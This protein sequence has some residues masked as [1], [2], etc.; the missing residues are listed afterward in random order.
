MRRSRVPVLEKRSSGSNTK[1]NSSLRGTTSRGPGKTRNNFSVSMVSTRSGTESKT[2]EDE[3]EKEVEPT[4]E[5]DLET[6]DQSVDELEKKTTESTPMPNAEEPNPKPMEFSPIDDVEDAIGNTEETV[7]EDSQVKKTSFTERLAMMVGIK[8][9]ENVTEEPKAERA[10]TFGTVST[11][12]TEANPREEQ[13]KAEATAEER[14]TADHEEAT[15]ELGDLMAKLNQIDK[16]LKHSEEDREV[17]RKELR[18]NKHEYLDSYFNL[19]KATDE[20]L[21]EMTD[22]VEA[23]NKERE[24]N[25]KKDLQQLKNRYDDVNSQIGSLEKRLDTMSKNQAESSGAIQTKLDAI[26]RNSTSQERPAADRTQGT[27]VDF[28]EPQ[29]GKRQSTPLPLTRNTVS[30]APTADKTITKS[31]NSNTTSGPGDSTASSNAGPDAMTWASTWE[32]MNRTLEAYATRNT[33]S[34]DRRDGKSRKTFKKPKEFKDDSDGCIDTWVE[35]M[36][37]HLEQDNLNDERQACTAI[38]SNLEGTALKCVVAKKEEERDTADKIFEILLNRFGS[39][40]KGHQAMMRFEKRRQRDDESIDRFLDDLES[41]RRRSDPEESTNRR[42]FSIASKFIDGVKSDDLRTMLATYYTLSKDSAP[43]PE[44]MRQKSREYMLMKPKKYSY[45]ENRNTQGGSQPQRSSWYKPRDDMDK[46]RSCANCGS[47]DHHVAD[48]TTYKQGM[49]SLGYAPDEEDMSQ[50]EEHE[51]YSGLIIKI[52]ARCFFCSQEGHFRM[53]CPLFWEAVKDQS[54]P[55]HKLALAA[56]QNQ[57]NR[58]NEFESRNLGAPST[59]LPT[60]TVK[61][62]T[63]VNGAIESAAGNSLEINYE[64]AVTEA[65]AKVKQ[66]LAAKEIEQRLKLEIERQNFNEALTGSNQTPEAVPGSTKTGNCNT[67]KMVTGKPFGISKIGAR[68]MSIITVGGH[69]VT[70]NLSEP[71]DQTIMHIDVY[72]DYLSC[73]SPQ[74]TSR[75]LRALLMRGGSKS[76]RVDSRYTEAY[77]PHEV[78][79]NIDGIN[80]YTKTMIT[81]DEDLIGQI[82]V[83]KEEL[84]VRSIGHCAMLEEDA[85]HIGTEADVTGHV[86]DISGK[87]TQL[88]GLLDTGAVLS[89]IP[90]ETWERMGFDK[91]DL[92]DSRIR[93]SAANKGALRVLGRTIIALNL[94]ERN[95]WMSFI[96]VENLDESDQFILGRDF[97]RNFDVTIDLNNAMFRIRNPDRR[98]AIKPVNLIMANENKAQVFLSRRVRL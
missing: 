17:I 4:I 74:T 98:Y 22:K 31:G 69:E 88:R 3:R 47:A 66:D 29:R 62:V 96:V 78:M 63:H 41:L 65:I 95:L 16:K 51:Y 18:Y 79:L 19:A 94:G 81:C 5:I 1:Y 82:Y 24:G 21:K 86:L 55:K 8:T 53:D 45:T 84:K 7:K 36:R 91:G 30:I 85:M 37:L 20:R 73:I 89:V 12:T 64:K 10:R 59:E 50:M 27:R 92:I 43:T 23:T 60:K 68:I 9:K 54:H 25:I 39:G 71:S 97:I 26:L 32:M 83:G 72:A 77:G 28:V 49:K 57:R 40:M 42:N 38:L 80:I 61:A 11:K 52:G 67:V 93:L 2:R 76:V 15:L 87:K 33:N 46:R 75:A 34:S 6:P 90:I 35:V 14:P 44:E 56:V 70:R 13:T 58:Q 48:C